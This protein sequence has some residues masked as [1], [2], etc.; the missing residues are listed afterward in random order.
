MGNRHSEKYN[1][2]TVYLRLLR[3]AKAYWVMFAAALVCMVL[4]A[5]TDVAV[6]RLI[7]PLTDGSFIKHDPTTIRWMP[8]AILGVFVVRGLAG[9]GSRYWMSC[10]GQNVVRTL[11][12]SIFS[13]LLA[14]PVSHH[15]RSRVADL[16]TKL[17]YHASQ[18]SDTATQVLTSVVRDGFSAIGLVGLMFYTSWKLALFTLLIAPFL[19]VLF[20]WVNRRFQKLSKRIQNSVAGITHSTDEAITG[21]RVVKVYGGESLVLKG[22]SRINAY[23]CRQN[24][25]LASASAASDGTMELIA[26]I[27]VAA[28]VYLATL[29]SLRA[30]MTPGAFVSFIGAMLLLRQPMAAMTNLAQRWQKGVVAGQELFEFLDTPAEADN[31]TLEVERVEGHLGF[32]ALHFRYEGADEEALRGIDLDIPTGQRVALVGRSGSGKSTLMSLI[33]RF[34]DPQDGAVLLDGHDLR[35]Y[36]LRNLRQQIALV[37]QNVVLFDAS[38]ADNIAYGMDPR[39][40]DERILEVARMANAMPFIERLPEGIHARVGA[41]GGLLSGG[42]RQ[43]VTIARA[44]LKD[45][46]ILLLDEATSALD[47]ESE[48]LVREAL[49]RLMVGRTTLVI[50]H[51][52]STVQDSHQIVVLDHGEIAETGTHDALMARDGA[53]AALYRMQFNETEAV[54]SPA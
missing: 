40:S 27:G 9:F 35:D 23:L 25:K 52:L 50:A 49:D 39:P 8:W 17:T 19:S 2:R 42:E 41:R 44:L 26:A 33:P 29:P 48:H 20:T 54:A 47:S 13:H 10:V 32:Q 5:G 15:D 37:D 4:V 3:Y 34:Y 12:D 18:V 7:K 43:R 16:Q 6:A 36:R 28:L 45:A 22:F 1:Q 31:G 38:I 11:R 51:R 53:Y 46:P 24:V 14:V 21:R 30:E